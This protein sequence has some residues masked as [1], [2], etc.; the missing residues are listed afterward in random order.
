[1]KFTDFTVQ[2]IASLCNGLSQINIAELK[3][4]NLTLVNVMRYFLILYNKNKIY[5]LITTYKIFSV[6]TT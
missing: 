4:D 2:N 6:Y 3:N 1:M 5:V